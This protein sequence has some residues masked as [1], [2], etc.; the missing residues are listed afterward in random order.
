MNYKKTVILSDIHLGSRGCRVDNLLTFLNTEKFDRLILVGDILDI[1]LIKS[2][3]YFP[4]KHEEVLKKILDISEE[5]PIIY[6]PGNHDEMM[7]KYAPFEMGNIKIVNE[8]I[9]NGI[10]YVHGDRFDGIGKL[11]FLSI[12]GTIGYDLLIT[13][14]RVLNINISQKAKNSIKSAMKFITNFENAVSD[15]TKIVGCHTVVCGHIHTPVEKEIN[16]VKYFNCGDWI[17]NCS[18]LVLEEDK[19]KLEFFK[20]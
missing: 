6:I 8:Y 19:I 14:D 1:W 12:I 15:H 20:K 16:K 18:F 4:K 5:V 17:E 9:E 10:Y 3:K 2:F 13:V 11:H 7:R